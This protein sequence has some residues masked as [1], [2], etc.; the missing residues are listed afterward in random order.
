MVWAES[1]RKIRWKWGWV[2]TAAMMLLSMYPQLR[3]WSIRA[4]QWNGFYAAMEGVGDEV[5]YSAYI[6][7]LIDGRPRRNDPYTGRDDTSERP[8]PDS[9]FS[10][11]FVPAYVVAFIART[12]NVSAATV[13]ILLAPLA[14]ATAAITLFLLLASIIEDERMAATGV[15]LILCLGTVAGGHSQI[16][17]FLGQE[18]LYNYLMFL[19]RYQPSASFPLFI[20][21]CWT[22]WRA[23]TSTLSKTKLVYAVISAIVFELL[24]FS[25]VYLWTAAIAW[26]FAI[27][28][29]W[30]AAGLQNWAVALRRL[31]ILAV[32]LVVELIPF[33][34]LYTRRASTFD[35]VQVLERSRLPDLFRLPEIISLVT[36][37]ALIY[38]LQRRR[39]DMR[40]KRVLLTASFALLPILV[41][42]QQ[43]VTGFSLQPIHYEMFV[44]N[45]SALIAVVLGLATIV[46]L[47][48]RKPVQLPRRAL[49][50]VAL[51]A[52]EWGSYETVV[53]T[54]GSM[55]FSRE[56]DEAR[57]VAT[58]LAQ[59]HK[60]E[61]RESL[62]GIVLATDLLVADSLPTSAP[63]PVLWAPHMLVFS[64]ADHSESRERFFQYLYYTG[65]EPTQLV[66]ILTSENRYGLAVGLF[67]FERAVAGLSSRSGT[68]SREELVVQAQAYAQYCSSFTAEHASKHPL[69]YVVISTEETS[70]F[71]NL[72][73]WYERGPG[74]RIGR[75][76]IYRTRLRDRNYQ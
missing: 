59:I 39:L 69:S 33:I 41:F 50:W 51:G 48:K 45:Y 43:I 27:W 2:V 4:G 8:Q 30:S 6:N 47:Q 54:A 15:V 11:Q 64:G 19:R 60:G 53:A 73:R 23:L 10:I 75:F 25:Y 34:V 20:L 70:D 37:A 55:P 14:A 61:R 31:L 36:L 38:L 65:V 58:R 68:I 71:S 1:R 17:R 9:L 32:I 16:V 46:Q 57:P 56:L 63:Q 22:V 13:F 66:K 72:D 62:P 21:F 40:D 24:V 29:L 67:G 35:A 7:A 52:F 74:E 3:F 18:P 5:A 28:L 26:V 49:L 76:M 44:A 12:L 42:N